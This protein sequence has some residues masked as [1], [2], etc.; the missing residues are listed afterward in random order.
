MYQQHHHQHH[1]H[2]PHTHTT[3]ITT[4]PSPEIRSDTIQSDPIRSVSSS[5]LSSYF[6]SEFCIFDFY[7][8]C[9]FYSGVL[10]GVA[11]RGS[12]VVFLPPWGRFVVGCSSAVC[13]TSSVFR[14]GGAPKGDYFEVRALGFGLCPDLRP[15]S[16]L[17]VWLFKPRAYS[18][19]LAQDH[20]PFG[21]L[22]L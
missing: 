10:L 4:V 7:A 2:H 12:G 18:L 8:S 15:H 14:E 20:A 16:V 17:C 13:F 1:Q 21:E 5:L 19:T 3:T 11:W 22:L 6:V 9:A